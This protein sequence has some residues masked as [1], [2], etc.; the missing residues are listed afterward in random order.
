MPEPSPRRA[1]EVSI[2]LVHFNAW[3]LLD[4]CLDSVTRHTR[5]AGCEIL[6]VDN[7]S[8]ESGAERIREKW[9]QV[10]WIQSPENLGFGRGNNLGAERAEG[11]LLLFLNADTLFSGDSAGV[12]RE[13]LDAHPR[14]AAVGPRLCFADGSFQISSGRF[15]SL[16]SEAPAKVEAALAR[17]F[18]SVFRPLLARRFRSTRPVDWLT[19]ACLMV[20]REA[21]DEVGGFDGRFFM[22]FEDADLCR[23][24]RERG[25]EVVY[26]PETTVTHLVA[27]GGGG[28]LGPRMRRIYRE[29]QLSY[30]EKHAGAAAR[31]LLRLYLRVTGRLPSGK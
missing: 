17:R 14:T 24:L 28:S 16:L 2:I 8:T 18:P 11:R 5:G 6:V 9:P 27:G 3:K 23:R 26:H 12:L 15:P 10:S 31:F 25:W 30:Y 29:S 20:R 13:Y 1:V 21:F 7:A 4:A 19:G 22:Y